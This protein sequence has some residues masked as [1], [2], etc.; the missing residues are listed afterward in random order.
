MVIAIGIFIEYQA[1]LFR[2]L[3][4]VSDALFI[5][6]IAALNRD[7][8]VDARHLFR[9]LN[10]FCRITLIIGFSSQSFSSSSSRKSVVNSSRF[11]TTVAF[12]LL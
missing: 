5:W 1:Y 9:I 10:I 4:Y 7:L 2:D 8:L 6:T 11:S 3:S 12:S